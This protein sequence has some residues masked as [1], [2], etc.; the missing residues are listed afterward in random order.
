MNLGGR[1][2]VNYRILALYLIT[3]LSFGAG[4]AR[5]LAIPLYADQL[6][7]SRGEIGLLFS[8][9]TITAALLS[10]PSGLLADRF[11]RRNMV[12]ISLLALGVSQLTAGLTHDVRV[13]FATQLLGGIGGGALQTAVM[14][15]L[16]DL[17]PIERM[18]R[19]MGWL[20]LAM[21]T[22]FLGGPAVAGIL[23]RWLTLE[24]DLLITTI[25][26]GV[27]LV[28]SFWVSGVG[29]AKGVRL[30]IRKPLRA[31]SAQNGFLALVIV[32]LAATILWGTYNAYIPIFGK[33]GL[34]LSGTEVGYLLAIQAVVN[35]ATR[36][37]AGR[38]LDRVQ[39]KG[40]V[41]ALTTIGFASGLLV[42]P[43]LSGF[44]VPTLL[45]VVTV[46]MIA[47]AFIAIGIVFVQMATADSRGT[48]MGVY[49]TVLFLG[50][51]AGPAMFAPLMDRSFVV[52]FTVCALVGGL[53]AGLSLLAR[54]EP[55]RRR[56]AAVVVPPTP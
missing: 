37:P 52:G 11:G 49:S 32:F 34:G 46:P 21:Q 10:L 18:G 40:V 6:G 43:H 48:A 51:G 28:L 4:G 27:A 3:A 29:G 50:L 56:R 26:V 41:V 23:L 8:T 13:L 5:N 47:T 25:P 2:L 44:W 7:A 33:R 24:D 54:S 53:L 55:I 45:L 1:T 9:F 22:G 19:S 31:L 15:A 42:L 14:A 17:V 36:V 35:G 16:A 20:T 38:L 30:E 12:V 39:R